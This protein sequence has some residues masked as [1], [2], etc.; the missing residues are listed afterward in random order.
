MTKWVLITG[1]AKRIGAETAKHLH[2]LGYNIVIHYNSSELEAKTLQSE[3]LEKRKG[4]ALLLQ[5]NLDSQEGIESLIEKVDGL[6]PPI[7]VLI[8]NASCFVPNSIQSTHFS[9][10]QHMLTTNLLTPYLLS[11]A[12]AKKMSNQG[13][14]INLLDIHGKRPLKEHGL[15]SITKAAL[16][17]ATLSLAQELAPNVR[18]NGVAPGAIIWPAQSNAKE[19]DK[20]LQTVPLQR[21]GDAKQI[22]STISFLLEAEYITGQVIAVDG[23]RS[24][25]GFAGAQ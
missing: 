21:A 3:L 25:V 9:Q 17:M 1:A 13:V 18:V 2:K 7:D 22:A 20:V 8:N 24:A 14:I 23:G 11:I 10:C 16:E 12:C 15:Y 19:Q 6:S 4:S 5:G